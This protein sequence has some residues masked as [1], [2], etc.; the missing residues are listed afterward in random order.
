MKILYYILYAHWA[1]YLPASYNPGGR[2]SRAIRLFICKHLFKECGQKVNIERSA[3][4]AS[5]RYLSVG[6]RSGLGVNCRA[7][8]PITIGKDVMMGPDVVL[9]TRMHNFRDLSVPMKTQGSE[10]RPVV[11]EDDVWI[12]TRVI[13][14]PGCTIGKGAII[15][16]GAVVTKDVPEYA[17]VGGS[18]AK[19]IRYRNEKNN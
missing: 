12:G 13:V 8:G 10:V 3:D 7:R 6:D 4:F 15:G 5:G 19:V 11:V 1:R 16:A 17:I 2:F 18:P 14:L 9:M